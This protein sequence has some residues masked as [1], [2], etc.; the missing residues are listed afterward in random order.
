MSASASSRSSSAADTPSKSRAAESLLLGNPG[1]VVVAPPEPAVV[2]VREALHVL[3]N[4]H[5]LVFAEQHDHR[6]VLKQDLLGIRIR[7]SA[8]GLVQVRAACIQCLVQLRVG[9]LGEVEA[10]ARI[11]QRVQITIRIDGAAP[12]ERQ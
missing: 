5:Y 2:V 6:L 11:E 3:A 12:A 7:L 9:V 10:R 1:L 4:R 8:L